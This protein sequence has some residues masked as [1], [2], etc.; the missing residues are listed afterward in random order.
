MNAGVRVGVVIGESVTRWGR[1]GGGR[2]RIRSRSETV[3]EAVT[4]VIMKAWW[5]S[6]RL[7]FFFFFQKDLFKMLNLFK[8]TLKF[9]CSFILRLML[10]MNQEND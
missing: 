3:R 5:V 4:L 7:T 9:K 8:H 2:M 10:R 6:T 1:R